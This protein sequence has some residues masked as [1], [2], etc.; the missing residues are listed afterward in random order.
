MDGA[1]TRML[2]AAPMSRGLAADAGAI[3]VQLGTSAAT[4]VIAGLHTAGL[5]GG[6]AAAGAVAGAVTFGIGAVAVLA[7]ALM[8]RKGPR[9]KTATSNIA[10]EVAPLMQKNLDAWHASYKTCADQAVALATFDALWNTLVSNCA[11]PS[12]GDPGHSCID[13]RMPAGVQF[14]Y[15]SFHLNGNG[16]YNWF[17]YYRDPI[18]NDPAAGGCCPAPPCYYPNCTPAPTGCVPSAGELAGAALGGGLN[19]GGV[20]IPA[21]ILIPAALVLLLVVLS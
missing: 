3:G 13:D 14:E 20:S 10:N 2:I 17:A 21:A 4:G 7:M 6:T 18:A 5:V 8:S 15:N 1:E 12:L 9:Q 19:L 11:Q 16:M